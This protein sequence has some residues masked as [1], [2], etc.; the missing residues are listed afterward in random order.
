ML[1]NCRISLVRVLPL[2]CLLEVTEELI[3]LANQVVKVVLGTA[4][5]LLGLV[6]LDLRLC[7]RSLVRQVPGLTAISRCSITLRWCLCAKL[8]I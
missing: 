7:L 2:A 6:E 5:L 8:K 3:L 4:N 1:R